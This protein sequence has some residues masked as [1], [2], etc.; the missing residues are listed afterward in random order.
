[1]PVEVPTGM[2]EDLAR[3]RPRRVQPPSTAGT[4]LAAA[5]A[6]VTLL[7]VGWQIASFAINLRRDVD[8]L[9]KEQ[10]FMHGDV[11]PYLPKGAE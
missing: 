7:T 5:V 3:R 8:E 9:L 2:F 4:W 11:R 6:F 10:Q 1:M